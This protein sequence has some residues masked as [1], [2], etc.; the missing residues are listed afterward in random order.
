MQII[1][2]IALLTAA[3]TLHAAD[4]MPQAQQTALV[5][6]YCAVCHTDSARNGG[7]SLQHFDASK[8]DPSLA[9]MLV[10]KLRTGAMGASGI[11][12]P[13]ASITK[14][15]TAALAAESAGATQ[16]TVTGQTAAIVRESPT[17]L[18]RLVLACDPAT[19][20]GDIQISWAPNA[21]NGTLLAS[22]DGKAPVTYAVEGTESMGNGQDAK[23]LRAAIK[24]RSAMP[25]QSLAISDLFPNDKVVFPFDTLPD[26]AKQTLSAC[27]AA[28]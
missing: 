25:A 15:L 13:D 8:L 17:S 12:R 10:S 26:A 22:L 6:K 18:Y 1:R 20:E 28:Q 19:H 9:A 2:T 16:W 11:P 14:A 21:T 23:A 27:F 4:L 24:L 3:V 5:L 7:L